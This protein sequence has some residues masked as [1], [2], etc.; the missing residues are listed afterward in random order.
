MVHFTFDYCLHVVSF[1]HNSSKFS[2]ITGRG[3]TAGQMSLKIP[4]KEIKEL[5]ADTG[6]GDIACTVSGPSRRDWRFLPS[7]LSQEAGGP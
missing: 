4:D 6:E 7:L 1:S 3:T 5:P 2:K